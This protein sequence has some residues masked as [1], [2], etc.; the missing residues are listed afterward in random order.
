MAGIPWIRNHEGARAVV[1][2]A[3]AIGFFNLSDGHKRAF[4]KKRF[5][6]AARGGRNQIGAS[7]INYRSES[8]AAVVF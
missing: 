8:A 3:E 7:V 6:T 2:L 4:P 5:I 1:E